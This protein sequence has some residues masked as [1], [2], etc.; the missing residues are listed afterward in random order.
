VIQVPGQ[1]QSSSAAS[2]ISAH[3]AFSFATFAGALTGSRFVDVLRRMMRGRGNPL[4]LI[5]DGL[6]AQKALAVKEYVAGLDG[7]LTLQYRFGGE[8]PVPETVQLAS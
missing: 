4:H 3:G 5:L 8:P 1:R 6:P 2:A 7:T